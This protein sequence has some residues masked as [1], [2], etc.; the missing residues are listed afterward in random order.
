[1]YSKDKNWKT[2]AFS[3]FGHLRKEFFYSGKTIF[4]LILQF[5]KVLFRLLITSLIAMANRVEKGT[6]YHPANVQVVLIVDADFLL[7]DKTE[8]I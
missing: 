6:Q 7:F 1:M 3:G 2:I 4:H 8:I 5:V